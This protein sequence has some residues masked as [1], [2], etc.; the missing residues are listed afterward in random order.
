MGGEPM[1]DYRKM[2]HILCTAASDAL[3]LLPDNMENMMGRK[4]LQDA[5]LEAEE[6]YLDEEESEIE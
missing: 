1:E 6:I 3:D 5:L 4:L 2:Y